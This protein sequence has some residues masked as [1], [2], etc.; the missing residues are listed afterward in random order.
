MTWTERINHILTTTTA[1]EI[2]SSFFWR[3]LLERHLGSSDATNPD[4]LRYYEALWFQYQAAVLFEELLLIFEPETV[5]AL[6][7]QHAELSNALWIMGDR[8]VMVRWAKKN[9]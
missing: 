6:F 4:D 3:D 9:A 2:D 7:R 1:D 8:K 5:V